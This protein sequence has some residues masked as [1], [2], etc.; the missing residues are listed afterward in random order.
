[1][2]MK[3]LGLIHPFSLN[4]QLDEK[5]EQV[6]NLSWPL[7]DFRIG[8]QGSDEAF[9][10]IIS[11]EDQDYETTRGSITKVQSLLNMSRQISDHNKK[12][13]PKNMLQEQVNRVQDVI[14]Q[15]VN[16]ADSS[17]YLGRFLN[18]ENWKVSSYL[19]TLMSSF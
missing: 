15:T 3:L 5:L 18:S 7:L 4:E 2:P 17:L 14:S 13:A 16:P 19:T 12:N 11:K 9:S 1:M 10:F 8:I 6:C